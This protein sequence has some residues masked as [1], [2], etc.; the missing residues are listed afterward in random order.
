MIRQRRQSIGAR[1]PVALMLGC[2]LASTAMADTMDAD[3]AINIGKRQTLRSHN[4]DRPDPPNIVADT[5]LHPNADQGLAMAYSGV[6]IDVT[7]YHYDGLRTGWNQNET[8]LTRATV[9]SAKFGKL[10]TLAVDG[11][12]YAEPLLVS[13]FTMPDGATH[14]VLIVATSHNSVYAFD[15][16]SYAVLWKVNLGPSQ[17]TDDVGCADVVPEYGVTSTPAIVRTAA[18]AAT[19]YLVAATE[20]QSLIFHTKLHAIDLATGHDLRT[21]VEIAPSTTLTD[22]ETLSFSA[23]NQWTRAGIAYN[24]GSLYIGFGSHCDND[25]ESITGWLLRYSETLKLETAFATVHSPDFLGTGE[26]SSIWMAGFAPA[27]DE[28]GDVFVATGNG[29]TAAA[30]GDYGEAA[31]KLTPTLDGVTDYFSPAASAVLNRDDRDFGSGGVMLLPPI[32]GQPRLAIAM[33]KNSPLYLLDRDN[34]GKTAPKDAGALQAVALS[35]SD[36]KGGPAYYAGPD[37]PYIY[38]QRDS[39]PLLGFSV[40]TGGKPQL[41]KRLQ[42]T[43]ISGYGGSFPIVSSH[44]AVPGTGVVWLVRRAHTVQLE[45]YDALHLGTPIYTAAAGKWLNTNNNAFVSPL[46]ANGRVYVPAYKTVTVFGLTP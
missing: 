42:G 44:G 18:N 25:S 7:T 27:I 34:M 1:F 19:I 39:S 2:M 28:Q 17:S 6:P 8:A 10:A 16:K 26:L 22:G 37:G 36:Y 43:T 21:P 23:Q 3:T 4:H 30:R 32:A 13:N 31:L 12:V 33:G 9:K 24:N 45:A 41:T 35:G 40:S 15:A 29:A 38:V 14:D 20:P 11:I 46:E 5:P